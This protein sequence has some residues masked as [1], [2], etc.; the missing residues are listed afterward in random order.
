[1]LIKKIKENLQDLD[2]QEVVL[3]GWVRTNR[4]S[5]NLGFIE[6][7]DGSSFNGMQVVYFPEMDDYEEVKKITTGSAIE[8]TGKI[9][10]TPESKQPAEIQASKIEILG[11]ADHEYPLQK[12]RHSFE[13]LR[14]IP[15]VRPRANTYY[16]MFR[17]RSVLAMAIHTFFQ[18]RGYVYVHTP[19]ITGNDAEGAGECF[20]VTTRTDQDWEKDFFA[21][22]AQLTVSGQLHVEPFALTYRNVYTFGPTFR[23]ENSNTT[24]H[25]SEFWMIEPEMA[26]ADLSDN[27]D[28]IEDMIKYCINYVLEH[29]PEEMEFFEKVIDKECINRIKHVAG[30]DFKRMTYTEAI[31]ELKKA[32]DQ[33][34]N[35][36]IF[37]GMD[38]QSE[39]ERYICEKV[40]QGP[41]FLTDYPKDIKAFYMR[42]NEDGKTVAAC[43]LLVPYV[44]ELVGGSQR[45]E[46]YDVLEQ[47]M[48]DM[49]ME[50]E[51][52][53]W[54]LDL[55]RFGGCKH[56]GFGLGFDR[57]L[58][59][60]SGVQNI[61]DVQPYPRTPRNL[62]F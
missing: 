22:H 53:Q 40:V 4:K 62:I 55:R 57:M 33:F 60:L 26:F 32:A 37:W 27:M 47:K 52:L 49:G 35:K 13:Y 7:N 48:K 9:V 17:L 16:A 58:M 20:T 18:D 19:E 61:R 14:E 59:Y 23:A 5:K 2:G 36:D 31:E 6:L 50:L 43:D 54:Y 12:K 34:E 42:E 51:P 15:H 8:V 10:L 1:M 25:A 46:R 29:A 24:R 11:M 44:G 38:L 3:Q 41:V 56:S 21:K 28:V 30:S 45:E 39:H